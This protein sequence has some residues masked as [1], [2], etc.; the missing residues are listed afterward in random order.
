MFILKYGI[1]RINKVNTIVYSFVVTNI[2]LHLPIYL[3][4]D[5]Y[6]F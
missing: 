4:T 1:P 3:D 2:I 5:Y 6:T